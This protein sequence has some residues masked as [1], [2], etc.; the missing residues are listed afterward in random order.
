MARSQ[1]C[2]L[3]DERCLGYLRVGGQRPQLSTL[4]P[5][6][7]PVQRQELVVLG[8][9][10]CRRLLSCPAA[11][12]GDPFDAL[13]RQVRQWQVEDRDG[14]PVLPMDA[15]RDDAGSG[16]AYLPHGYRD[17]EDRRLEP[18]GQVVLDH[19]G[20]PGQLLVFGLT[21]HRGL[22]DQRVQFRLAQLAR[23]RKRRGKPPGRG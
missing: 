19:G 9:R 15:D 14:L 22:G 8:T 7:R 21:V 4:F 11:V 2:G 12:G 10:S 1:S 5:G 23:D 17:T 3:V 16:L 20:E 18:Y 13:G 6:Q